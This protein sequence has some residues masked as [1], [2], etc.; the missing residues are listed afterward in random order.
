VVIDTLIACVVMLASADADYTVPP[1]MGRST[2]R[3]L[4]LLVQ[5]VGAIFMVVVDAGATRS[6][7]N[8]DDRVGQ[9][10]RSHPRP[11]GP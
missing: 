4:Y 8:G 5:D 9:R 2:G 10:A 6:A 7:R 1:R 11:R 3:G